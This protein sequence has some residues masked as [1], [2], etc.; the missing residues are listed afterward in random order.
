MARAS[1]FSCIAGALSMSCAPLTPP[2]HVDRSEIDVS[3]ASLRAGEVPPRVVVIALDGVRW[4]EIFHGTDPA[5]LGT[6][7]DSVKEAAT[8]EALT[9]NLHAL[10]RRGVGLGDVRAGSCFS[11]A[12]PNFV[13][14]PGYT[15][16]FGGRPATCQEND[17]GPTTNETLAD[18]F[19]TER[20]VTSD[21]ILVLSS[22]A[23]IGRVAILDASRASVSTGRSLLDPRNWLAS[24][25][26]PAMVSLLAASRISSPRPGWGDYRPD[27]FT[28]AIAVA[29]FERLPR[30]RFAF[31]GLGDTDEHGHAGQYRKYLEALR[32]ADA[33]VGDLVTTSRAWGTESSRVMWFVLADHGR[34]ANFRDHGRAFAGSDASWLVAAGGDIPALGALGWTTPHQLRDLAPTIRLLTGL[35]PVSGDD[36]GVPMGEIVFGALRA[37]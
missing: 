3:T 18:A 15:E 7:D 6:D 26:D 1:M 28:R 27:A 36:A 35:A 21:E 31:I 29:R 25:D 8:A 34:G 32:A 33:L 19:R 17:C 22:W 23:P 30:P 14:L 11:A 10:M 37:R 16:I 24:R 5:L 2:S 20:G 13:S 4:Q 12:G 9:P